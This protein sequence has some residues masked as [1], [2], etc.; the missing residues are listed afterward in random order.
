M[1]KIKTYR[2]FLFFGLEGP[3]PG[4]GTVK[5]RLGM[6]NPA[7]ENGS[8]LLGT[9]H[10]KNHDIGSLGPGGIGSGGCIDPIAH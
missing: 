8:R 6:K 7:L 4:P 9:P 3:S 1:D 5:K 2:F 10:C